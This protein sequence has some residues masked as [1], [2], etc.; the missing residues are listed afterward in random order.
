MAC[1]LCSMNI[2]LLLC[3]A[4]MKCKAEQKDS[5]LVVRP[6]LGE[7]RQLYR[8]ILSQQKKPDCP[9]HCKHHEIQCE[10]VP[11]EGFIFFAFSSRS[12]AIFSRPSS[13]TSVLSLLLAA[14]GAEHGGS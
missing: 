11:E 3:D 1:A 14:R 6:K 12:T 7:L 10:R 4:A 13:S 5:I 2:I 9:T 8:H